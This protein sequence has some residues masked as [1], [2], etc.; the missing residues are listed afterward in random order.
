ML[1]VTLPDALVCVVRRYIVYGGGLLVMTA[2]FNAAARAGDPP[3]GGEI[4]EQLLKLQEMGPSCTWPRIQTM[5]IR[6]C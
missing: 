4:R 5:K 3:S 2:L 1:W 6:N